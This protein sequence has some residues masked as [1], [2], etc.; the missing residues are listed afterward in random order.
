MRR[1]GFPAKIAKQIQRLGNIRDGKKADDNHVKTGSSFEEAGQRQGKAAIRE[2]E[3]GGTR[4]KRSR[5]ITAKVVNY[6][7]KSKGRDLFLKVA[8]QMRIHRLRKSCEG[9]A[10]IQRQ[11]L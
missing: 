3:N 6:T 10:V 5:K 8:K 7:N 2:M 1:S 11:W 9:R 4:R